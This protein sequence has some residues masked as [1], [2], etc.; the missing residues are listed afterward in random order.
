MQTL[1]RLKQARALQLAALAVTV[2]AGASAVA[3]GSGNAA[4]TD[5]ARKSDPPNGAHFKRPTL[6]H[7]EL[8]IKGTQANDKIA[9]R[10]KA[11]E[12]NVLQVDLDDDG[13]AEFEFNRAAVKTIAVRARGGDDVVRID[14]VNGTFTNA[15]PTTIDGGRGNDNLAGGTGAEKLLGGK[16][17][18]S[19]DGNRG[20]DAAVLGPGD[21]TFVWDPGDGSDTIEGESG[22]DTMLFNGANA[23][24][25]VTLTANGN[26]LTFFRDPVA[27]T[28]DTAGV[29]IVDFRALGGADTV[30]VNDLTGTDVTDV[31]VDLAGTP[32][33]ATGDGAI[34]RV[35]VNAT[36]GVDTI[37]V[38]GDAAGLKVVGLAAT[39]RILHQEPASDRL[40]INTL[41]GA[42]TVTSA[43][44]AAGAVR[45]FLDGILV[46]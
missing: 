43:G 40:E 38:S 7:G 21:D 45:F 30:T 17:D 18:D 25:Q 44:L 28:M 10:L 9:L 12:P 6:A 42:D 2:V 13:T 35:I 23:A 15:I 19:V 11:G 31:S 36:N 37:D 46:P 20:D 27:I 1:I 41:D 22:I 24:E 33:G 8:K 4:Q 26:R 3:A 32:N 39:T 16:G 5:A 29:E 14:E 34:D